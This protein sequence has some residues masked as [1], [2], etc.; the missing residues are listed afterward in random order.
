MTTLAV[1]GGGQL[2]RML[3]LAAIPLGVEVHSLDPV[4]GAPAGA[5]S[6]LTVGALDD[7]VSLRAVTADAVVVTYEWE[8]VPAGPVR[9]LEADGALVRPPVDALDVTQD[10]LREKALFAEVGIPVAEYAAV[11]DRA[12]LDAAIETVGTPAILKTCRG[13][14][15]G[16]GQHALDGP[17]DADA[18]WAAIG[19]GSPLVLE[20]RVAFERELSILAVRGVDGDVRAWPLVEN[21]HR[22]GLL[23]V[24]RAPAPDVSAAQQAVAEN[25]ARRILERW[26]YV[27]VLTI[28]LFDSGGE[29]LANEMA[30]RVHN[31][32]HWTIE[33]AVTSQFENH[34]RAVLGWP[35]GD[36]AA[37]GASAMVNCVGALPDPGAVLAIPGAHLHR[38]GKAPRPARKVG[39]VTVTAADENELGA[40]LARVLAITPADG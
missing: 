31:S 17:D 34:V 36:T 23:R 6:A 28:E 14:Y 30:P 2:G 35:L 20:R 9:A 7:P 40:R 12:E 4:A 33:G 24:S 22:G 18:A 8:G 32:G 37:H 15:D 3:A 11:A 5:V 29:L 26:D 13:G 21:E 1:L 16:K 27:G 19:T 39:H 10:R 38:Y 25:Y